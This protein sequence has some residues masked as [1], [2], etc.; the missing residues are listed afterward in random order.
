MFA[1]MVVVLFW[2]QGDGGTLPTADGPGKGLMPAIDSAVANDIDD[3]SPAPRPKGGMRR[4]R[5]AM[6]V[7]FGIIAVIG[8]LASVLAIW[9]RGVLFDSKTVA[10]AVGSSLEQPEVSTA[11]AKYITD[12]VFIA[13]DVDGRVEKILPPALAGLAPALVSGAHT[14]VQDRLAQVLATEEARS[15]IIKVVERSHAAMMK[16]LEGDGLVDGISVKDGEVS[17]NLLPLVGRGLTAAQNL[18]FLDKLQVPDLAANGDP[19]TQIAALEKTLGRDLPD[20]FGQVVVYR[21][22]ALASG[23]ATLA[24]AQQTLV[25]VKRSIVLV[26][27]I[28]IGSFAASILLANRRRRTILVLALGATAMMVIARV[29]IRKIVADSPTLVVDPAARA[30]LSATVTSLASGLLTVVVLTLLAGLVVS[31]VLYISGPSHSAKALRERTGSTGGSV[32]DLVAAHRDAVAILAFGLA[33]AVIGFG[34]FGAAQ[35]VIAG[36]LA[37]I[38]AWAQWAPRDSQPAAPV[39]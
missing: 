15:I 19:A 31:L 30:A 13:A 32:M 5:T 14:S 17:V 1:I 21:S 20:Q 36:I 38:G 26:I 39:A 11:L 18:G 16:L 33:V 9:A 6:S 23:G 37:L 28:T 29:L 12:Q 25:V 2:C 22:E 3:I 8:L 35:L 4:L 10:N 7:V 27:A 34:G 24:R